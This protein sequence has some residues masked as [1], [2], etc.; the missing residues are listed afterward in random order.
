[1]VLT[2][3]GRKLTSAFGKLNKQTLVDDDAIDACLKEVAA[4]LLQ[5]DVNVKSVAALRASVKNTLKVDEALSTGTNRRRLVQK[6]VYDELVKLVTPDRS[7]FKPQKSKTNVVMFVGLQGSGKT[8]TCTK[9]AHYYQRKGWKV[10]LVCADTFRAGAFDQLK[11][12]ATKTRVPFYGS[13]TETDPVQIAQDGVDLFRKEKYEIVIVDTSGRHRQEAALFEE[14]MQ[15]HEVVDPNDVIFV[16]DSHIGQAC[17]D[18]AKAFSDAVPVGSVIVTKLDGHA[19][20]GGALSAVSATK[21]P[22]IF[23]GTGEHFDEFEPFDSASF[24][25][26]LMGLGDLK[27]LVDSIKEAMP[28]EEQKQLMNRMQH[29]D[30]SLRD[31][32]EQLQNVMKLGPLNK[33]MSMIPGAQQAN[34]PPGFEQ[35]GG[36]RLKRFMTIMDSMTDDELDSKKPMNDERRI[37]RVA[38]GAGVHPYGVAELLEEQKR[39]QKLI[40]NMGKAG[41]MSKGGELTNMM[42]NPKQVMQKIQQSMDPKMIQQMG[43]AQNVFNMMREIEKSDAEEQGMG[44]KPTRKKK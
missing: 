26:R 19:K 2:D 24:V 35:Q 12:N 34:M 11:Q 31:L 32:Y 9:Y 17:F 7:P 27:G 42:R 37:M 16:M 4:A 8:T 41:L 13:Y 18:Q 21:A 29:G 14:M 20:G 5:S 38:R 28:L 44:L 1:M 23:I 3:L 25:S 43:G 36:E 33:V 6:C 10:A 39:F 15:I 40:G 30:F 22:I